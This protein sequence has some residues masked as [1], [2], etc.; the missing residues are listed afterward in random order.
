MGGR[1]LQLI[2]SHTTT[3]GS[4]FTSRASRSRSMPAKTLAENYVSAVEGA[5]TGTIIDPTP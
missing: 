1:S 4:P 5:M 2:R 3:G